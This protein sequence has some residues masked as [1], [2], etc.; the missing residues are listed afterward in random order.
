MFYENKI[1]NQHY[2]DDIKRESKRVR[3][4]IEYGFTSHFRDTDVDSGNEVL[5]YPV[6]DLKIDVEFLEFLISIFKR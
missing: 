5:K 3:V 4:P 2:A 6:R 1:V